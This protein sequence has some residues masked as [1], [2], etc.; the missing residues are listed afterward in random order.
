MLV[1][2]QEDSLPRHRPLTESRVS[3]ALVTR[4]LGC[5]L[6]VDYASLEFLLGTP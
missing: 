5:S 2:R 3:A 1:A 4:E 6:L